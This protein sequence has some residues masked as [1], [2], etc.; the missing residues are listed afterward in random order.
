MNQ[1]PA[2]TTSRAV[3]FPISRDGRCPFNV[4]DKIV[5]L[6]ANEPL[7][8]VRIWDGSTPWLVT[9]NAELR[10]LAADPRVSADDRLPGFP[11]WNEGRAA[12]AKHQA[13]SM[14]N[15]DGP[16]HSRLRRMVTRSFAYK[17]VEAQREK[18]QRVTDKLIDEMLAGPNP[19]D[20]VTALALPLPSF[21]ICEMLGTPYEDHEFFQHH[22]GAAMDRNA[23]PEVHERA[24][25][26]LQGYIRGLFEERL[27][28]S[29]PGPGVLG[30]LTVNIRDADLE[31]EE[32]VAL[33]NALLIA[34][35]ETSAS[36]I[37]LGTLAVLENPEQR[38]LLSDTPAPEL[39]ADVVEELLRYLSIVQSA[40]RRIAVEGIEIGGTLI[41]AGEGILLDFAGGSWDSRTF[42][43]PER[44]DLTR[45]N[46]RRHV[47]FGIGPHG[48][49]GQQL[50][51]VELQVAFST[52]FR[53]IP[54]L[55]LAI[56]LE[57][58][59]F[60]NDRLAYGVYSLPVAW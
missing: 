37:A 57:D 4:P 27:E 23:T 7:R 35:H 20:L 54:T 11:H 58:V 2:T 36:I 55:R 59:E 53:R 50:A 19:V 18:M 28:A 30:E 16:A 34:G 60:M 5:E 9:G 56:P 47:A 15:L 17:R 51:R 42:D 6:A 26:T 43:E 48:C 41:R 22:A 29:D 32:A 24:F 46:A 13:D 33:A 8:R 49:I 40:Q 25:G 31:L 14:L 52:I 44:F 38:A 21:M 45:D 39:V 12:L 10:A 1:T 3:E